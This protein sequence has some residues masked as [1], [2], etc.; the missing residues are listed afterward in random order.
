MLGIKMSEPKMID[1]LWQRL[2]KLEAKIDTLIEFKWKIIGG[3]VLASLMMTM[4]IQIVSLY[5]RS[6]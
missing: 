2:D 4:A 6:K 5:L 3:T 1:L